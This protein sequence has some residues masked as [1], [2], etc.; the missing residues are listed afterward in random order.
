MLG[1]RIPVIVCIAA[2]STF[3]DAARAEMPT[4]KTME[5]AGAAFPYAEAGEGEPVLFIHGS[6][7][8]HRLWTFLWDDV[9]RDHRVLAYTQR[10]HGPGDWP[11]DKP[12]SR[13]VHTADLVALLKAWGEP[14]H[15]VGWSYSGP[16]AL[17]AAAQEPD[18]VKSLVLF[19]PTAPEMVEGDA[20]GEAAREEWFGLWGDVD[21]AVKA[22][23]NEEAI[24]EG[25]E[26]AFGLPEGGFET[27]EPDA[28]AMLLDNAP[29]VPLDWNAPMPTPITCD[30][31]KTVS[32]PT[33][34]VVGSET[35]AFWDL[36]ARA[37]ADCVPD[38]EVAVIEGVGHGGPMQAKDQ[39]VKLTLDF[40]G[41]H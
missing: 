20:E 22:N 10:W 28:Q 30:E 6:F 25:I 39:F 15:V 1:S 8:D 24:R 7:S 9:A 13:D 23:D 40:I 12:Y 27:L 19:E 37:M 26:A 5:A 18:L 41:A 34:I 14:M 21:A 4:E 38:A 35:P 29:T 11:E 36:D 31:L 32:A 16:I 2:S 33:L 17:R 3:A